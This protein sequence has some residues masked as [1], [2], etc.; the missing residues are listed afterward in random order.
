M[1]VLRILKAMYSDTQVT[2]H[3]HQQTTTCCASGNPHQSEMTHHRT[4]SL[5]EKFSVSVPEQAEQELLQVV[6]FKMVLSR[7]LYMRI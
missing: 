3:A 4:F 7:Y 6:A 2:S 5:K 1:I